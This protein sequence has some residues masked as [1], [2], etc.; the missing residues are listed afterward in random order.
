MAFIYITG[1]PGVGKTTIQRSLRDKGFETYDL[2][3]SQFGGPHSKISGER[4]MIPPAEVRPD[5]WFDRHEWRIYR[6]SLE[7]LKNKAQDGD[8]II[9]GV[10]EGDT[11][12]LDLFDR[13]MYLYVSSDILKKRLVLRAGN[14]Y[15]KNP[16][17]VK[18]ILMRKIKLDE[19]YERLSVDK[20]EASGPVG[21]EVKDILTRI[22]Y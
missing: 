6:S 15:G 1:A 8:I 3:D 14:D 20:V 16:S 13:I 4:V 19:K 11:D 21:S 22:G 7:M 18:E 12:I 9:C 5:G 10:A 2:D 17:E